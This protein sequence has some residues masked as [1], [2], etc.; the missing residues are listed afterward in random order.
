[1]G[2]IVQALALYHTFFISRKTVLKVFQLSQVTPLIVAMIWYTKPKG[3]FMDILQ[4]L[5]SIYLTVL[6]III[7]FFYGKWIHRNETLVYGF[8]TVL[9]L[10]LSVI[11]VLSLLDLF[12]L[13]NTL[14]Y[15]WFFQGHLSF[16]LIMPVMFAG[17]LKPKTRLKIAFMQVRRELAVIAT[18]LLT[19]HAILLIGV[20]LSALNPTGTLAFFLMIP[21]MITSFPRIRKTF[22]RQ[23]WLGFHKWAYI[24]YGMIYIH[25]ASI[26]IIAQRNNPTAYND[27]WFLRFIFLTLIYERSLS[28]DRFLL[29][30]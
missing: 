10:S 21:L 5:S 29:G 14:F 27:D 9:A 24:A 18:L 6:V 20:A 13:N 15:T 17:V 3:D 28:N 16:A 26:Q 30:F 25:I 12:T 2:T 19:P 11:S 1:M 22:S 23:A 8:F 4:S 7:V